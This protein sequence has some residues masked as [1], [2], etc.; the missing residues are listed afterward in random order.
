MRRNGLLQKL[1]VFVGIRRRA[2]AQDF[3]FRRT[4]VVHPVHHHDVDAQCISRNGGPCYPYETMK[5]TWYLGPG[6]TLE[7]KM[8]FSDHVGKYVFHCHIVEH[9][10]D[11]MMSQFEVVSPTPRDG[12]RDRV[13]KVKE[14]ALF[15][16]HYYWIVD[17]ELR[18]LEILEL[19]QDGRYAHVL[20]ASSG[21]LEAV[22]GCE[23]LRLDL[24]AWWAEI[25]RLPPAES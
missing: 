14:Y 25:D 9:E 11:G 20:G 3:Q 16:I 24:D 8:K 13:E 22:P 6:E 4:G 23:G 2:A 7:V 15:G 17:S 19:G 5:E 12:R 10:D 18:T 21:V 1:S